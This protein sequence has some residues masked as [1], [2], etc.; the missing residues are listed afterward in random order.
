MGIRT[1]IV[2]AGRMELALKSAELWRQQHHAYLECTSERGGQGLGC[3][4]YVI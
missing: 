3:C 2:A 4:G 1:A